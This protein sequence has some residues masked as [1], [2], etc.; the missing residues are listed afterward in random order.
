MTKLKNKTAAS[1]EKDL[2]NLI[3]QLDRWLGQIYS[4]LKKKDSELLSLATQFPRLKP[5]AKMNDDLIGFLED[6]VESLGILR[7]AK[8][9]TMS[10]VIDFMY[11]M[12]VDPSHKSDKE[13]YMEKLRD[14]KEKPSFKKRQLDDDEVA[15]I[16][17][18][19]N[20]S[21]KGYQNLSSNIHRNLYVALSNSIDW[22]QDPEA[23]SQALQNCYKILALS[24]D[25][26]EILKKLS[27]NLK[28]FLIE[29]VEDSS[30]SRLEKNKQINQLET[31]FQQIT[32]RSSYRSNYFSGFVK[33]AA[34]ENQYIK[35]LKEYQDLL[36]SLESILTNQTN[37]YIQKLN[38][39][40]ASVDEK[41][42]KE[43][44][45]VIKRYKNYIEQLFDVADTESLSGQFR[46]IKKFFD[47]SFAPS[48]EKMESTK[49]IEENSSETKTNV[50]QQPQNV[51]ENKAQDV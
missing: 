27:Q 42:D 26:D 35:V 45:F 47:D 10:S 34:D 46:R 44:I 7:Q 51:L 37:S 49:K 11:T 15:G 29:E 22:Q 20:N 33:M 14:L 5:L 43:T 28:Q 1:Q 40:L 4:S 8:P 23:I 50:Q 6:Q 48:L 38:Q 19:L 13:K 36:N 21:L 16:Q 25:K 30:E 9:G 41:T 32:S 17:K 3:Q 31:M 12:I 24:S 18:I 39:T 2:A